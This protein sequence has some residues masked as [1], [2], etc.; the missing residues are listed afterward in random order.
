MDY[1]HSAKKGVEPS[2]GSAAARG[3]PREFDAGEALA[4]ALQVFRAKGYEGAS[5]TELTNAMGISRPSLYAAFGNK[6][7]LFRQ[8]LDLYE[9]EKLDYVPKALEEP[10][11]R[12]VAKRMLE[13]T[14]QNVMSDCSGCMGVNASI[15]GNAGNRAI[16]QDMHT[17]IESFRAAMTKRLQRAI[18]EGEFTIP[19]SAEAT[20][21]FL[22]AVLQGISVQAGAG[23]EREDLEVVSATVLAV[24]PSR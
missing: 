9:Q 11:A 18:D 7:S 5:L 23:A 17:R 12:S 20:T 14:I 21:L 16:Q 8:A 19:V 4:S 1:G 10:T 24:W 3:R 2:A 22:M 13:G 15:S 6:E